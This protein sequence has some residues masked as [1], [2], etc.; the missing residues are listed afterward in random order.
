LVVEPGPE[1]PL[2]GSGEEVVEL[3][4]ELEVVLDP[5]PLASPELEPAG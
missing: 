3:V 1:P 2:L 4:V 5:P